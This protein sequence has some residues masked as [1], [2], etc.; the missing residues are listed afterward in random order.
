[1]PQFITFYLENT[2][3]ALDILLCQEIGNF[4]NITPIAEAP[5]YIAGLLNLRGQIVTIIHIHHFLQKTPLPSSSLSQ[6][7]LI[8]L[9]TKNELKNRGIP[10][11]QESFLE[12]PLAIQVDKIGEILEVQS[13]EILPPTSYLSGEQREFMM[14][15]VQLPQEL[16]TILDLNR[17]VG[18][19][20]LR[21]KMIENSSS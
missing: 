12:D 14:G 7:R 8:L 17:L 13:E 6:K 16:I 20:C 2:R 21:E 9:R 10:L 15:V 5:S 18:K 3:Y 11:A 4:E 1:M 19:K